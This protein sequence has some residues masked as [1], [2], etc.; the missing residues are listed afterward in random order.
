MK[1]SDRV[2]QIYSDIKNKEGWLNRRIRYKS[3]KE[4]IENMSIVDE[5]LLQCLDEL[6]EKIVFKGY[7]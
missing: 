3:K 1:P 4:M 5:A 7:R 2:F 6:D